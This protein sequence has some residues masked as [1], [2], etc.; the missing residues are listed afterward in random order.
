MGKTQ[1]TIEVDD[2]RLA[3]YSDSH[4]ATLW[5]VAQANQAP[6][7]DHAAGELVEHIGREI[8]RRWLKATP[9]ELW[10]HQGRSYY[11]T[12]LC[13]FAEFRPGAGE[14]GSPEWHDGVW[15][16]RLGDANADRGPGGPADA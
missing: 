12:E 4:L 2:D 11:W 6:H 7:G 9:P 5:H 10:K 13:K 16:P 3:S 8:I 15:V 1:I 14:P